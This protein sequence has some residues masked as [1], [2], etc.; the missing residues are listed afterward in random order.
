[1]VSGSDTIDSVNGW[2]D[3]VTTTAA[4]ECLQAEG[5]DTTTL[6]RKKAEQKQRIKEMAASRD[7]GAPQV[8]AAAS[9]W[10]D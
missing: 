2:D 3:F 1:L 9:D 5:G 10:Y 8:V 7:T 4:I 6:E